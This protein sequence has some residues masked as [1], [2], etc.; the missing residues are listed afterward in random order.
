MKRFIYITVASLITMTACTPSE[1]PITPS[2]NYSVL[3]MEFPQGNNSWDEDIKEI[4][5]KYGVYLL[6]KDITPADLNR[7]WTGIGTGKLYYGDD[8]PGTEVPYYVDFFKNNVFP[9]ASTEMIQKN[10]PV[11]IYLQKDF[12]GVDP[13]LGG[14]DD[15]GTGGTGGTGTGGTGTGG[16]GG[17]GTGTGGTGTGTGTG[18]TGTGTGTGGTGTGTGTGGTGTGT[19]TGGTGTGTGTGGT[20][21]GTGTGGTGTGTGTGGT[22]TGTGT[23][24]TGTGTGT[25]TGGTGTGT[26]TGGTGTGTDTGSTEIYIPDVAG[27][28]PT[29]FDGFDYWAISF[30][31]TELY[32][33]QK[34]AEL[35][36]KENK[37]DVE[38]AELAKANEALAVKR[39]SFINQFLTSQ[40]MDNTLPEP[41]GLRDGMDFVSRLD[42][43]NPNHKNYVFNRGLIRWVDD[44]GVEEESLWSIATTYYKQPN[45]NSS[46]MYRD[47][48]SLYI[49][50]AMRF[51]PE[52][53]YEKYPKE[54][55]PLISEKYELVVRYMKDK[56][57]IDLP[58][59]A[60]GSGTT[61]EK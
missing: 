21:T 33:L 60:K 1:D 17:T 49:R 4:H 54:K 29:K 41:E 9:Y 58:G 18:G 22:G 37:T 19:G 40:R 8:V 46:G 52:E 55:Y 59:I 43:S 42:R 48:F 38:K 11:K 12:R 5:D 51:S 53:F 10:F 28:T 34:R 57:G 13:N 45:Y 20:G 31:N 7:K 26:G 2:G 30:S 6:Y 36:D 14:G 35:K 39:F 61:T 27:F 44:N 16:T 23:G 15:S 50:A 47:F 3:R 56:Y 25:G 32:W 24:G